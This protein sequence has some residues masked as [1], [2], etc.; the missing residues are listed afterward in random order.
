MTSVKKISKLLLY[1][2]TDSTTEIENVE[3]D[4][5]TPCQKTDS[6]VPFLE[7]AITAG[8]FQFIYLVNIN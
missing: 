8:T 2:S 6:V 4:S 7:A 5:N 3:I 1:W